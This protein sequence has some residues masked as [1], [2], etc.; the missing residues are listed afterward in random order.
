L[1][2]NFALD[3]HGDLSKGEHVGHR[4]VSPADRQY[5]SRSSDDVRGTLLRLTLDFVWRARTLQG[6]ARIALL[7]SLV[8]EKARPKDADVLVTISEDVDFTGLAR[9]GRRLKGEAQGINSGADVF[10]A[11]RAGVY[12][13]RVCHY[14]ACHPRMLC[15]ARHCGARPHLNDDLDDVT[16]SS[17]VIATPPLVLH[18]V[19]AIAAA[20][21]ADVQTLL[22]APLRAG[23]GP[24]SS[25]LR[26]SREAI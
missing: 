4:A 14:R 26:D 9:L 15:H 20:I 2:V 1:P 22:V 7:G 13:G 25:S 17:E 3:S 10:L 5:G 12:L 18:P 11:D 8:T 16:I 23:P 21:P 6:V 24:R 19:V